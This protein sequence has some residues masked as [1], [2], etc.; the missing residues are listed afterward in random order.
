MLTSIV[1]NTLNYSNSKTFKKLKKSFLDNTI[2][3]YKLIKVA[4]IKVNNKKRKLL[5]L[6]PKNQAYSKKTSSKSLA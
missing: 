3:M 4:T 2:K 1:L 5:G 6:K